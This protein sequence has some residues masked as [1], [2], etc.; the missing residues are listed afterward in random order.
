M[1]SIKSLT[2]TDVAR[3]VLTI[4]THVGYG[5][6][7]RVQI[8]N[9]L[10]ILLMLDA[11]FRV[12]EV[13]QTKR[14]NLIF[15]GEFAETVTIAEAAAKLRQARTIPTTGRLRE[16]LKLMQREVWGPDDIALDEFAFYTSKKKTPLSVRQIQRVVANISVTAIGK[17]INPHM[18]RHTFATRLMRTTSIRIVQEL[19]GHKSITSTQIYT[20]PNG[21]DLKAAIGGLE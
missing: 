20:H 16:A 7:H 3:I 17:K 1:A 5:N 14:T 13:R 19:L 11:G 2:D 8:R 21:E 9:S 18:L 15:A 10:L 12:N 4:S 6:A